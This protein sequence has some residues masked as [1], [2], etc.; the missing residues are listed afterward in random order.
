MNSSYLIDFEIKGDSRGSLISLESNLN[1]P[2]EVKRVY[3][4]FKTQNGVSRGF[5]AHKNLTQLLICTSG[6]CKV[7]TDDGKEKNIYNLSRPDSGLLISNIVWREM[8]DFSE[9]CVLMVL[10][11][12]LYNE[13][14]YIRNY[15]EFMELIQ[16]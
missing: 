4:I 10:A 3:Y 11:S 12:D 15:D 6:S 8:F 13:G 1:I 7:S 9:D 2:F 16:Q 5:H 14:D